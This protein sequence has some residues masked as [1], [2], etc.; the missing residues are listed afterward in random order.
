MNIYRSNDN[1]VLQ[2]FHFHRFHCINTDTLHNTMSK[3]ITAFSDIII[4]LQ[5][6]MDNIRWLTKDTSNN[7]CTVTTIDTCVQ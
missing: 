1:Q 6:L 4:D 5:T 3:I 2:G 7:F